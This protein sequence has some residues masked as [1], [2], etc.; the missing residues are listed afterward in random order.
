MK[1]LPEFKRDEDGQKYVCVMKLWVKHDKESTDDIL[2]EY[3]ERPEYI[4]HV[5]DLF[6]KAE[7]IKAE[8]DMRRLS[9]GA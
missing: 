7:D 3:A 4:K 1:T 6:D 2:I 9:K 5:K 8:L